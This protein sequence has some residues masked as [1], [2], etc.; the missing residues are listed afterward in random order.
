MPCGWKKPGRG[1]EK[2]STNSCYLSAR[3]PN[4]QESYWSEAGHSLI[5]VWVGDGLGA[6][7]YEALSLVM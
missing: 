7:M 1:K 2:K 3:G 6:L 5:T 4:L